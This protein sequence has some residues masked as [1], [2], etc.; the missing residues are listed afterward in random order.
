MNSLTRK[1][2]NEWVTRQ[3]TLHLDENS[4]KQLL[5][6]L[7]SHSQKNYTHHK[8]TCRF[9]PLKPFC[10]KSLMTLISLM[11]QQEFTALAILNVSSEFNTDDHSLLT[12]LVSLMKPINFLQTFW[13]LLDLQIYLPLIGHLMLEFL[14]NVP[15]KPTQI[16]HNVSDQTFPLYSRPIYPTA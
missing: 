8:K 12:F 6:S 5:V 14:I 2:V 4:A 16:Y 15:Y 9:M 7:S 11:Q 1:W 10:L 13:P 3:Q